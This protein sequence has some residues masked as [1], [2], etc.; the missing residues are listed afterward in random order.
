MSQAFGP[1]RSPQRRGMVL[2]GVL[3]SAALVVLL[4]TVGIAGRD[5][6]TELQWVDAAPTAN[7]A[8]TQRGAELDAGVDWS[9][10]E[11]APNDAGTSVAA[12]DR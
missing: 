10:V 11:S 6:H 8:Q 2:L 9:R 12:Y 3:A 5:A 4:L 7:H 1:D